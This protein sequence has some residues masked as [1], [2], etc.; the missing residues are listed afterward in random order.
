MTLTALNTTPRTARSTTPSY[1]KCIEASRRVR[2]DIERDVIRGRGFDTT[3]KFLPDGLSK[4]GELAFLTAGEQRLLSQVQGRS[5]A[6]IFSFVERFIAAKTLELSQSHRFGDQVAF[7]A[8]VRFTDEELKHQALFRRLEQLA[9]EGMPAGYTF[10]ADA[11]AVAQAVLGHSTWAVLGLAL[12]IEIF[13]LAHY[14]SSIEPESAKAALDPLWADVFL[15]HWKEESQH[16]ILD[17]LEWRREHARLGDAERDQGVTGLISLVG[18]VDRILVQQASA[19]ATYFVQCAARV[20][21]AAETAAVHD[22]VLRAYRWQYIVSGVQE[23][24][25]AEVMKELVTPAQM[26]RIGAALG[27]IVK[28]VMG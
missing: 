14:R 13:T 2:W 28:H 10:V 21:T 20:F 17:E 27:P 8:L 6:N 1:A 11:N 24:R 19:D 5:Y 23:P 25:F 16:A 12:D 4:V 26:Q 3:K 15:F 18:A 9:S 22:L 7:E